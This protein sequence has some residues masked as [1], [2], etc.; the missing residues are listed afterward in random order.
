MA[1]LD[2]INV[3]GIATHC[4]P[5]AINPR[6]DSKANYPGLNGTE[7]LD[8]GDQ[9]AFTNI[10]GRLYG[11]PSGG[12]AGLNSAIATLLSYYDGR[13]HILTDNHGVSWPNVV[14]ESLEWGERGERDPELGYTIRYTCR[15]FH[16]TL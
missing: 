3:F 8:M 6:R 10:T 11:G 15:F 7:R 9:G 13:P 4:P 12:L 14:F 5:P 1:Q 2:G 16:L